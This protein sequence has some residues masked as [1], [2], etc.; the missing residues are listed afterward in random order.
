MGDA[1]LEMGWME[2]AAVPRCDHSSKAAAGRQAHASY[3]YCVCVCF[4]ACVCVFVC[5]RAC[6]CVRA[7]LQQGLLTAHAPLWTARPVETAAAQDTDA[8]GNKPLIAG[9][10]IAGQ[11]YQAPLRRQGTR[12]WVGAITRAW[13]VEQRVDGQRCFKCVVTVCIASR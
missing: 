5:V 8:A 6:V 12:R 1:V 10:E 13:A 3:E 11:Q 7:L 9:E 4:C 2:C